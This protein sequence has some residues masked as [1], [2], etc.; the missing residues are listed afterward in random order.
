[1]GILGLGKDPAGVVFFDTCATRFF[2][3]LK[4]TVLTEASAADP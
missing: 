1:M 2:A 3:G 4:L